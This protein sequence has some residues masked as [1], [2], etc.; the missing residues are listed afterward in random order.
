MIQR[1][2]EVDLRDWRQ[3]A[4]FKLLASFYLTEFL[5]GSKKSKTF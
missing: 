3:R 4:E 1:V 2:G 5:R